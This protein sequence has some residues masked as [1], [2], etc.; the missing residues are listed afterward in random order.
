M[1]IKEVQ[2]ETGLPLQS[3]RYYEREGLI[4]PARNQ[5]NRYRDYSEEDVEQLRTIAFCRKLGMPICDIRRYFR[6][7]LSLR[8][9]VEGALL[10]ARAARDAA[11]AKATLCLAALDQLDRRPDMDALSCASAVLVSPEAK[12]L[13]KQ[14]IPPESRKPK[15][16]W[17]LPFLL[18][19]VLPM[20]LFFAL[21]V[22]MI[23]SSVSF[24]ST[25]RQ[26]YLW[27]IQENTVYTFQYGESTAVTQDNS[28]DP[29]LAALEEALMAPRTV[30]I[31]VWS[32]PEDPVT[33]LLDGPLGHAELQ[34]W[35][36]DDLIAVRW[37]SPEKTVT[38]H[39]AGNRLRPL[40]YHLTNAIRAAAAPDVQKEVKP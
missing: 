32:Q 8:Q 25:L 33:L 14:V 16:N 30:G 27:L 15:G 38:G 23:A 18:G 24:D 40:F 19:L 13:Y 36:H 1:L 3:I 29:M 21:N 12:A 11:E 31:P 28:L 20:L 6:Q 5:E 26:V 39:L 22:A 2:K 10:D 17:G 35:F 7:E 34:L 37:T 4:S 9:C